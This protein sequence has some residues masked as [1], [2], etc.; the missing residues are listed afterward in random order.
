MSALAAVREP[1]GLQVAVEEEEAEAVFAA[2]DHNGSG[3]V[4]IHDWQVMKGV[5]A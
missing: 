3:F 1:L 4:T 5:A 2:L